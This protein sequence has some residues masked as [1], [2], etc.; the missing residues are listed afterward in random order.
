[1]ATDPLPAR[2]LPI[3][4]PTMQRRLVNALDDIEPECVLTIV[5]FSDAETIVLRREDAQPEDTMLGF[6]LPDR[7]SGIGV[8]AS[9]IIATTPDPRHRDAALGLALN[10]HGD[11]V[12]MLITPET[13]IS[14]RDPQGWL[15]DASLRAVGLATPECAASPLAFSIA[16]W[17]DR[18]MVSLVHNDHSPLTW[19]DAVHLCPTPRRWRSHDPIDLGTTLGSTTQSWRALR[20]ATAAGTTA[21]VGVDPA[22]AAWMDDAMFARW[23]MG[24]FP[25]VSSLRGDV[26]F[27]APPD[28]AERVETTLRAA[29]LAF[30]G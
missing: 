30:A 8:L 29:W 15:M 2:V 19:P 1:M 28:V 11:T 7:F 20:L 25:D 26:E 27:L 24:A 6:V 22:H 16:L 21:P 23:C 14:T 3:S 5:G 17:L 13:T 4:V 9:S 12:S 18:L 10:R